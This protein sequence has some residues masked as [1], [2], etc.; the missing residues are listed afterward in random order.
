MLQHNAKIN[1]CVAEC[2]DTWDAVETLVLPILLEVVLADSAGHLMRSGKGAGK[3]RSYTFS[4][5]VY[6]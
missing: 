4:V 3:V 2:A 6:M 5:S 1:S